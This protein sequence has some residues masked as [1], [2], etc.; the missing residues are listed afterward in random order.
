[1]R[2]RLI[3]RRHTAT[4]S[5]SSWKRRQQSVNAKETC[6]TIQ[7]KPIRDILLACTMQHLVKSSDSQHT[8]PDHTRWINNDGPK[9]PCQRKPNEKCS[10]AYQDLESPACVI[11]VECLLFRQD[12]C[13]ETTQ[14]AKV[15]HDID[16]DVLLHIVNTPSILEC[17]QRV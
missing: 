11:S 1:M 8:R 10:Q 2:K 15:G 17:G 3:Q 4:S 16:Q 6:K 13:A 12:V 14:E 5:T 7:Y 9:Q